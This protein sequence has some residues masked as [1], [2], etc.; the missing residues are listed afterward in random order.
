MA[1]S[2]LKRFLVPGA[3][4]VGGVT[5]GSILAPVALAS[6]DDDTGSTDSSSETDSDQSSDADSTEA[7][8]RRGDGKGLRARHRIWHRARALAGDV[9]TETLGMTGEE[10]RSALSEGKSLADIAVEQGVPVEDLTAAL[11]GAAEERIDQAVSAGNLDEERAEEIKAELAERIDEHVNRVHDGS[12]GPRGNGHWH[13]HGK[14]GHGAEAVAEFLGMTT[15]ELRAAHEDG[16]TLAEIA[17]A[18]GVSEDELVNFLL[19]K[20]QDRLD[21]AAENGRIDADQVDQILGE[22]ETRIEEHINGEGDGE[23]RFGRG[24]GHR[25]FGHRHAH[26]PF[27]HGTSADAAADGAAT[28]SAGGA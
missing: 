10:L 14:H 9:V 6:A 25:R 2:D 8:G 24:H 15:D 16:Q 3:L 21:T 1:I 17:Q 11:V 18:Q 27:H 13:R 5:V 7:D 22:A 4:V 26:G 28:D 20:L 23:G 19:S 12:T